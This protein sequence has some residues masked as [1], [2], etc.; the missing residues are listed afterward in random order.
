M[1]I[2]NIEESKIFM[3]S[4]NEFYNIFSTFIVG[5]KLL[6]WITAI[7]EK[8]ILIRGKASIR[9]RNDLCCHPLTR[10][11]I[12]GR[13]LWPQ[14]IIPHTMQTL[15]GAWKHSETLEVAWVPTTVA[16][17]AQ[18]LCVATHR[19]QTKHL[20]LYVPFEQEWPLQTSDACL[21][22]CRKVFRWFTTSFF[23]GLLVYFDRK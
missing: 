5:R 16:G 20:V 8:S 3:R 11:G 15:T 17:P 12:T 22:L 1:L 14:A 6:S 10:V 13:T 9:S 4:N 23:V 2:L 19:W 7:N 18:W 21:E